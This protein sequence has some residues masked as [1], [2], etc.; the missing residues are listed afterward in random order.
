MS[1]YAIKTKASYE[2]TVADMVSDRGEGDIYASLAPENMTAYVIVEAESRGI[3][4]RAVDDV[5]NAH[6]LL[7]GETSM[8]EVEGFLEPT[9]DV[10]EIQEGAV[11]RLTGGPFQGDRAQ[12]KEIDGT[13][14][15]V[16]VELYEATVPIPVEVRGD[17]VKVL[18]KDEW[19]E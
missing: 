10:K 19:D 3:V 15:K 9:S 14:E 6:K 2:E 8:K 18:D 12:V 17:Q 11:V 5:P 7:P 13:N 4:E 16:T 1:L